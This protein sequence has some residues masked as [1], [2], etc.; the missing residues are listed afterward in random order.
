MIGLLVIADLLRELR[1]HPMR[2]TDKADLAGVKFMGIGCCKGGNGRKRNRFT[3]GN[4]GLG[5][6]RSPFA[7]GIVMR[8]PR[9]ETRLAYVSITPPRS[10]SS[11]TPLPCF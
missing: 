9:L 8:Y 7:C 1:P 3:R 5:D 2:F 11:I 4:A 6:W 10:L